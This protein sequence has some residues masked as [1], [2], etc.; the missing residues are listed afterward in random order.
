[1]ST[2]VVANAVSYTGSQE[3]SCPIT[4]SIF[5]EIEVPVVFRW[6]TSQP[7]ECSALIHWLKICRR[8]PLTNSRLEFECILDII[9]P[10]LEHS[11][12]EQIHT[13]AGN[14][15]GKSS[16]MLILVKNKET[17]PPSS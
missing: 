17:N 16:E 7:Y 3:D 9:A 5:S 2:V 8:D 10:L 4:Q 12:A 11:T 1:M 6:N 14:L 13:I 15:I